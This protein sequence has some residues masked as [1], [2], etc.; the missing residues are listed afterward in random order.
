MKAKV[1]L[2][3]ELPDVEATEKE[4]KE[5]IRYELGYSWRISEDNPFMDGEDSKITEINI[6][7]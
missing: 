3:I 2:E 5:F 7:I 6:E 1:T 4:A